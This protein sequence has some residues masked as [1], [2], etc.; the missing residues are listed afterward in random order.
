MNLMSC[1]FPV[2][3]ILT[4]E[5]INKLINIKLINASLSLS[6]DRIYIL[7]VNKVFSMSTLLRFFKEINFRDSQSRLA[8]NI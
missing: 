7:C 6:L 5:I 2:H 1:R 8:G 4:A 3:Q